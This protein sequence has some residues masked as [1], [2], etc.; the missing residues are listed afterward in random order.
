MLFTLLPAYCFMR[1][2]RERVY[3]S[4]HFYYCFVLRRNVDI[5]SRD[6][7]TP[8][9]E[10]FSVSGILG[11]R[12]DSLYFPRSQDANARSARKRARALSY[13][14]LR[15]T[16][17]YIGREIV[18][19]SARARC[20]VPLSHLSP[21]VLYVRALMPGIGGRGRDRAICSRAGVMANKLCT[22]I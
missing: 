12:P 14:S 7:R 5:V 15:T 1:E 20:R 6:G 18:R 10:I 21:L 16:R 13:S 9:C 11:A 8:S 4:R 22:R 19:L 3:F 2:E 17:I